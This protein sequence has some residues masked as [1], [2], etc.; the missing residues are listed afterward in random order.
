MPVLGRR[1]GPHRYIAEAPADRSV[2][3][4]DLSCGLFVDDQRKNI[5]RQVAIL[6]CIAS[7]PEIRPGSG[8][9]SARRTGM[10]DRLPIDGEVD[11]PLYSFGAEYRAYRTTQY[12]GTTAI[13]CP[14]LAYHRYRTGLQGAA[15]GVVAPITIPLYT[16]RHTATVYRQYRNIPGCFHAANNE[17]RVPSLACLQKL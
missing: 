8:G 16:A 11:G 12:H 9:S 15:V 6:I 13:P 3:V 10:P 5:E 1:T 7:T 2:T 4:S 14:P 17:S